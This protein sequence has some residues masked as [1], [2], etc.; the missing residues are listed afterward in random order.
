MN[1]EQYEELHETARIILREAH[2]LFYEKG[3]EKSSMREIA[4]RVGISKA[5]MYHH[6]TNKEEMLYTLCLVAG[7]LVYSS[8]QQAIRR[9][10]DLNVPIK[11]QLTDILLEYTTSYLQNKNFN[12]ILLHD[13]ES[14]PEDKKRVILDIEKANVNQLRAYLNNLM[15]EGRLR[16]CN[17]TVLTFSLFS[18]VHWLY[19]WYRPDKGLSIKEIVEHIVDIYTKGILAHQ[20]PDS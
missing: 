6:F 12:K 13:I 20:E 16:E 1:T 19:F 3:Y 8:L 9:N 7:N 11:D 15:Q 2:E 14:L 5:A 18:A 17:L 4:E 10:Q